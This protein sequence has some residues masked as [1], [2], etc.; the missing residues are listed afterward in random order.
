MCNRSWHI[1]GNPQLVR[2]SACLTQEWGCAELSV[3]TMHLND[4]L[5]LFEFECSALYLPLLLFS[6]RISILC[7]YTSAMTTDHF[8]E[9]HDT[10]LPTVQAYNSYT[11]RPDVRQCLVVQTPME[12][13]LRY[14]PSTSMTQ[15]ACE[16]QLRPVMRSSML[17]CQWNLVACGHVVMYYYRALSA[18][19]K[20]RHCMF[21]DVPLSPHSAIHT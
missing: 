4:L 18:G 7:H 12:N 9:L 1:L 6:P 19:F 21:D 3:D 10:K 11:S 17:P 5:V 13:K 2:H 15:V 8:L 20:C 14:N 16:S